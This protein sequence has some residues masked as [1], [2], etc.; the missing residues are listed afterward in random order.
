MSWSSFIS[1]IEQDFRISGTELELKTGIDKSVF[2][3]LRKGITKK[4]TQ[5]TLKKLEQGLNI[6]IDDTDPEKILYI[7]NLFNKDIE[8]F[9]IPCNEFAMVSQILKPSELF[10]NQNIIGTITLPYSK[11]ENCFVISHEDNEKILVDMTAVV[12]PGNLTA[13]RLKSTE[14]FIRFYR[15]LPEN[16]IQLYSKNYKDEPC[17]IKKDQIECLYRVVM[18]F[19]MI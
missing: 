5:Q 2:Y 10:N 18:I 6:K 4:P 13:C 1:K 14:Q 8:L 12:Q 3:K 7:Q 17:T 9:H 15:T 16:Y 19:K 11:R